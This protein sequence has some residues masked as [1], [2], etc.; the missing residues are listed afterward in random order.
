MVGFLHSVLMIAIKASLNFFWSALNIMQVVLTIPLMKFVKFPANAAIFTDSLMKI[1]NLDTFPTA[2]LEDLVYYLPEPVEFN[3]NFAANGMESTLFISNIGS[4]LLV[5]MAYILAA[6][7][8]LVLYKVKRVW[9]CLGPIIYWNGLIRLFL[10]L[11]RDLALLSILNLYTAEWDSAYSSVRFS[12]SL[13]ATFFAII[14]SVP[15]ILAVLMYRK[16]T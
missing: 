16:R 3:I 10:E 14:M 5:I 12:N 6:F 15:I 2:I 8:C 7:T 13:S 1:A 11:Y 9:N 4:R